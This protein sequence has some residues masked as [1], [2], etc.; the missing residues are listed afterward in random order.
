MGGGDLLVEI[1]GGE[2]VM[3]VE[4]LRVGRWMTGE[5]VGYKIW[6]VKIN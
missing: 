6:R 2:E 4:Q 5:G 1:G 3:D